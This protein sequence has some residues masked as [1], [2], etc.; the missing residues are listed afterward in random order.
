MPGFLLTQTASVACAHQGRGT[1]TTVNPRVKLG[2]TASIQQVTPYAVAGCPYLPASGG[3][4]VTGLWTTG[5]T[6]VTSM[7]M[8]LAIMAA[9]GTCAPTGVPLLATATQTRVR[10]T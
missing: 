4:C 8:P 10:A 1:P 6:R 2:G 9:P 7:G 3:P 5:T